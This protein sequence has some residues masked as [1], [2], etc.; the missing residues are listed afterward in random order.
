MQVYIVKDGAKRTF[1]KCDQSHR[2]DVNFSRG[3]E[4]AVLKHAQVLLVDPL[5]NIYTVNTG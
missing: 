5:L 2:R 4:E 1:L 3:I